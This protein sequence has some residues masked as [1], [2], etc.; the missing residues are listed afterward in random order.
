[1][2]A[3]NAVEAAVIALIFNATTWNDFA[4]NDGSSPLTDFH[5]SLHTSDPGEAGGQTTNETSYTS[6][7]REPVART[8]GGWTCSGSSATLTAAV[9]FTTG[10]G[11]SGTITHFGVGKDLSGAGTLYFKGTATPNQSVGDGVTPE[12]TTATAVS[13]D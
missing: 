12:L 10:T 3:T 4:Q 7:A 8:S 5:L 2:S 6:Y 9:E 13:L 11:G 1:M